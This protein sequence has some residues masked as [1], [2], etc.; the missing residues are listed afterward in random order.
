MIFEGLAGNTVGSPY[1]YI[2]EEWNNLFSDTF[3]AATTVDTNLPIPPI[4]HCYAGSEE[5]YADQTVSYTSGQYTV[6]VSI[7]N[8]LCSKVV[9]K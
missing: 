3:P 8:N 4:V 5:I 9:I 7:K 6:N 2:Y 1:N